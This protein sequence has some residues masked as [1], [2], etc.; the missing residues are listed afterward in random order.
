MSIRF[1]TQSTLFLADCAENKTK[2]ASNQHN[3]RYLR[4]SSSNS[5]IKRI[6]IKLKHQNPAY[7]YRF[8]LLNKPWQKRVR[9]G[10]G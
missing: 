1:F 4:E 6:F 2:K 9:N 5:T 7:F 8:K 3:R 10:N